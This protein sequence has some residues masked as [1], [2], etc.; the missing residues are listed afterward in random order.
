MLVCE[1][2]LI[3]HRRVVAR[4]CL[5]CATSYFF[6]ENPICCLTGEIG[7]YALLRQAGHEALLV[8]GV[9]WLEGSRVCCYGQPWPAVNVRGWRWLVH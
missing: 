2:V 8:A 7:E 6:I 9:Y 3:Y 4:G 1:G 5:V